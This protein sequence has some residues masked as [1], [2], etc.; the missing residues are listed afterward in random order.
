MKDRIVEG[1]Y[2]LHA[3]HAALVPAV[4]DSPHSGLNMP[5]DWGCNRPR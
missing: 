5:D 4:F 2:K 1:V 3:P